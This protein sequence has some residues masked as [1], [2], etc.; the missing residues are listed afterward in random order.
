[1]GHSLKAISLLA[2]CTAC[3]ATPAR[4]AADE[5]TRGTNAPPWQPYSSSYCRATPTLAPDV[6]A[7][8]TPDGWLTLTENLAC[9]TPEHT[10][11]ELVFGECRSRLD[12]EFFHRVLRE[13]SGG[14]PSLPCGPCGFEFCPRATVEARAKHDRVCCYVAFSPSEG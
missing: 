10:E 14:P 7:A 1:M 8:P 12:F 4:M 5:E 3:P 9:T 13:R 2:L 6:P 11:G